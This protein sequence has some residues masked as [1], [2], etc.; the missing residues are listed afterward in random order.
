MIYEY[1]CDNCGES[2]EKNYSMNAQHPQKITCPYCNEKAHR[3]F[4][5]TATHIPYDF[6]SPD[7][8]I[9]TEKRPNKTYY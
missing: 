6:T 4:S 1:K 5:N 2:I 3:V 7:N 9:K 8:R